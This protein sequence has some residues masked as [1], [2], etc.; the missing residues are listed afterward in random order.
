MSIIEQV[1]Y[2]R[3]FGCCCFGTVRQAI[4]EA[5][6][7]IESLSK[8]LQVANMERSADCSGWIYCGDGKNFQEGENV[9][10]IVSAVW[11]GYEYTTESYFYHGKFYNK[12]Y[13]Q[14]LAGEIFDSYTGDEVIAWKPLPEPYHE[15]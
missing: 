15:P 9:K 12:P 5:S 1:K 6:D 2:L 8:K 3:E 11:D 14:I 4:L 7:T 10:V 13:H